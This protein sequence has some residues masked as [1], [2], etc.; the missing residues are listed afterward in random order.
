MHISYY[1]SQKLLSHSLQLTSQLHK[2]PTL[3]LSTLTPPHHYFYLHHLTLMTLQLRSVMTL[4]LIVT[5]PST[6]SLQLE[7]QLISVC[8][9]SLTLSVA[10][11]DRSSTDE[12]FS[13]FKPQ[14]TLMCTYT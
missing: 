5:L 13:L 14:L 11:I 12:L 4:C 3:L 2:A 1:S 6:Q 8:V 10:S 7:P 9:F